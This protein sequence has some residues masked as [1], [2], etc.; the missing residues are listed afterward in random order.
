MKVRFLMG[1]R[2]T[3]ILYA[4]KQRRKTMEIHPNVL[5]TNLS[6]LLPNPVSTMLLSQ[7]PWIRDI[8]YRNTQ[9]EVSLTYN[10]VYNGED[11]NYASIEID[12]LD[13]DII[14]MFN[15]MFD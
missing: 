4:K 5:A 8:V 14:Q 9:Y 15:H 3:L 1:E 7:L 10:L 13:E 6:N 11:K 12:E 2:I